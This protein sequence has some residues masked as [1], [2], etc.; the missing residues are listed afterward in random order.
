MP[1]L[2]SLDYDTLRK[3][4]IQQLQK[5]AGTLWTNHNPSDPG[6]TILEQLCYAITDLGYRIEH[7]IEDLLA[8][9]DGTNP[10][11]NLLSPAEN[12]TTHPVTLND[13]RKLLIDIDG[14]K[15]AWVELVNAP[16]PTV[17]YDAQGR[18]L[19]LVKKADEEQMPIKGI[20]NI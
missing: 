18:T 13:W 6:I 11:K 5:L 7:P 4:G 14:V 15:N 1:N 12:L 16:E 20:Y 17:Y 9:T 3:E 2:T 8:T 10:Y 19:T